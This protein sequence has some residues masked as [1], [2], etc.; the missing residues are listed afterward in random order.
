MTVKRQESLRHI[1]DQRT[2][3][4][5]ERVY[6]DALIDIS[7]KKCPRSGERWRRQSNWDNR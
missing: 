3:A 4:I 2:R 7:T 5:G 1:F 6:L